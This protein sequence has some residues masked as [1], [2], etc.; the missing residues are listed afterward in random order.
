MRGAVGW[1]CPSGSARVRRGAALPRRG[2]GGRLPGTRRRC[3]PVGPTVRQAGES[4]SHPPVRKPSCWR[5]P[6]LTTRRREGRT[7]KAARSLLGENPSTAQKKAPPKPINRL[8]E[9]HE[10]LLRLLSVLTADRTAR[11]SRFDL[12]SPDRLARDGRFALSV[13]RS[14]ARNARSVSTVAPP[15]P[16]GGRFPSAIDPAVADGRL[17][18]PSHRPD[19]RPNRGL[20]PTPAR[21]TPASDPRPPSRGPRNASSCPWPCTAARR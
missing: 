4:T 2:A 21:T 7:P 14:P 13:A 8:R 6:N 12:P 1:A 20:R 5:A 16:R 17:L 11:E 19:R 15:P 10:M 3:L 18:R 9:R